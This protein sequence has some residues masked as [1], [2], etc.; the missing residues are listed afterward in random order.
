MSRVTVYGKTHAAV[1]RNAVE[2]NIALKEGTW[3]ET[4]EGWSCKGTM[5][6]NRPVTSNASPWWKNARR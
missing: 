2:K 1:R 5:Q 3:D 6:S 4:A